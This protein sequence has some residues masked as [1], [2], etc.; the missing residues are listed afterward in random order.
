M[1]SFVVQVYMYLC[2]GSVASLFNVCR[3]YK[4]CYGAHFVAH[5]VHLLDGFRCCLAYGQLQ[6]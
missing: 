6:I 1:S 2:M 5:A 3:T 4:I